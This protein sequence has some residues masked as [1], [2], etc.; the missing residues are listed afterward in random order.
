MLY[1]GLRL[2]FCRSV[3][4]RHNARSQCRALS[5]LAKGFGEELLCAWRIGA[6]AALRAAS[7][8]VDRK[9]T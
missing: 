6:S 2:R 1:E 7:Y 5:M 4:R 9:S 3:M 8:R